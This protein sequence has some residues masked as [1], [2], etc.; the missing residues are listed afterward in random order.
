MIDRL[1][2]KGSNGWII[3]AAFVILWDNIAGVRNGQ[4][5]SSAFWL[6]LSSPK[7]HRRA[8]VG[9][10]WLIVTSHLL[11]KTPLPI[12]IPVRVRMPIGMP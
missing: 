1:F 5:L 9:G 7:A 6:G 8:L 10:C 12:T 4:T 2:K 3:L 11:F